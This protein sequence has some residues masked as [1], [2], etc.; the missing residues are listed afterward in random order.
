MNS[1]LYSRHAVKKMTLVTAP[2]KDMKQD[3]LTLQAVLWLGGY[4]PAPVRQRKFRCR[5][6]GCLSQSMA[7]T[8]KMRFGSVM[9]SFAWAVLPIVG[10]KARD[11]QQLFCRYK[12]FLALAPKNLESL[13]CPQISSRPAFDWLQ[14]RSSNRASRSPFEVL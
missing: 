11:G 9:L 2:L 3:A 10:A 6:A 1:K 8:A 7:T 12:N 14:L 5:R 4:L 13:P